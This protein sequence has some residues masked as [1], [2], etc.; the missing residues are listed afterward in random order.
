MTPHCA[1]QRIPID[2]FVSQQH[3]RTAS[4]VSA[5][6]YTAPALCPLRVTQPGRLPPI[7]ARQETC[8]HESLRHIAARHVD[9]HRL[10]AVASSRASDS[11]GALTCR[12][13]AAKIMA[14]FAGGRSCTSAFKL[15]LE[16]PNRLPAIQ[17]EQTAASRGPVRK[18]TWTPERISSD[19]LVRSA[20]TGAQAPYNSCCC[21]R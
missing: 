6:S 13:C 10:R 7:D 2:A 17:C 3:M 12:W 4:R 8:P 20:C 9:L 11:C 21:R 19:V 15:C 5:E 16:C 18:C 1:A 14:S